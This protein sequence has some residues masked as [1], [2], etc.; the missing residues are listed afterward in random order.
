MKFSRQEFWSGLPFPSPEDL[1]DPV[2]KQ[3][4]VSCLAGRF[5]TV[6][7]ARKAQQAI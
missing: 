4:S 3:C 7:A 6:G 2:M 1:P 5:F